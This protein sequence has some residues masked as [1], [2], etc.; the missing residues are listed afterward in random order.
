MY[1]Q[2]LQQQTTLLPHSEQ[3]P[4]EGVLIPVAN[5][6]AITAHEANLMMNMLSKLK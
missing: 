1:L 3:N 6:Q 2:N 4:E 5:T